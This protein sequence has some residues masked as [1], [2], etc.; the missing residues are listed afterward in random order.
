MILVLGFGLMVV[1]GALHKVARSV[2]MPS[3]TA[4]TQPAGMRNFQWAQHPEPFDDNQGPPGGPPMN[5]RFQGRPPRPERGLGPGP[6]QRPGQGPLR[7]GPPG[8]LE[9]EMGQGPDG[10]GPE[11]LGGRPPGPQHPA[12]EAWH[13]AQDQNAIAM[14]AMASGLILALLGFV[15]II[16][17]FSERRYAMDVKAVP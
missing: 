1:G 9:D 15:R 2:P 4:T 10:R 13:R 7:E 14:L 3:L 16:F 8:P 12:L 6:G 5:D 17:A 11:G